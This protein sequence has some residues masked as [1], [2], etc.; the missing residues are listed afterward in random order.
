MSSSLIE[1]WLRS[2]E[3][4]NFVDAQ[5]SKGHAEKGSDNYFKGRDIR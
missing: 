3:E 2:Q 5:R 1:S 4:D